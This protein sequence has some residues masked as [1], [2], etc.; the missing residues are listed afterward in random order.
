MFGFKARLAHRIV[1]DANS[2]RA[3]L[4][5]Q[6]SKLWGFVAYYSHKRALPQN[7]M[8]YV[9]AYVESLDRVAAEIGDVVAS[10][11]DAALEL[12]AGLANWKS[13]VLMAATALRGLGTH[14][15]NDRDAQAAFDSIKDHADS[16]D[17]AR[18]LFERWGK[19]KDEYGDKISR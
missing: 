1:F 11:S 19:A 13:D 2:T 4:L 8:A 10:S 5:E 3:S 12:A 14:R 15:S 16:L 6:S 9:V 18:R 17:F 7:D